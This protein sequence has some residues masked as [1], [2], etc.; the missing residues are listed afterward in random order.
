MKLLI[1]FLTRACCLAGLL[2]VATTSQAETPKAP[3][4]SLLNRPGVWDATSQSLEE[5]L[6]PMGFR[7]TS[8]SKDSLRAAHPGISVTDKQAY[9]A[10]LRF[11][12]DKP[13]SIT[14]IFYNRGD[15]GDLSRD[16]F[17]GLLQEVTTNLSGFY[18]FQPTERGRDLSG[19][20]RADGAF[21]KNENVLG[22]LEWSATKESRARGIAFRAEFIRLVVTS[23]QAAVAQVGATPPPSLKE[24]VKSF[25]GRDQI[26]RS[27]DG[28]VFLP[29]IPMV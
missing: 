20:V 19:A 18:G 22:T 8:T 7:W 14:V 27:P 23:P 1:N 21:W 16:A 6:A 11:S 28:D 5:E 3:L 2:F 12:G 13:E 26:E 9:E 10:I 29:N 15:A 17:E 25:S 24:V 4:D